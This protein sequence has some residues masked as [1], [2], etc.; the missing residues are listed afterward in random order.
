MMRKLVNDV[1]NVLSRINS[2]VT[3]SI[4][5][6]APQDHENE[7][8]SCLMLDRTPLCHSLRKH[9]VVEDGAMNMNHQN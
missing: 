9:D 7:D 5:W 2:L 8:L 6:P 3:T 4:C 1:K